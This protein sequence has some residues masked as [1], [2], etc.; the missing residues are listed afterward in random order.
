MD[1]SRGYVHGS[2]AVIIPLE[3]GLNM[4]YFTDPFT[5]TVWILL[6]ISL[7]LYIIA[8]GLAHYSYSGSADWDTLSG[9]VLRNALSEQTG[10]IPDQ[11]KTYHKILIITWVGFTLILVYAYAGS[12]T[13]MLSKPIL[14]NPIKTLEELARQNKIPWVIEKGS[15]AEFHMRTALPGSTMSLLHQK[16]GLVP[17]LTPREI[18]KYGCPT[19]KLKQKGRIATFCEIHVIWLMMAKDFSATGK[20]N[21]YLIEERLISSMRG[22]AFQVN[23]S[24]FY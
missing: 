6:V 24:I 3:T 12:L 20:C 4:W 10:T 22:A 16:A 1:L 23:T 11:S 14:Q 18:S 21:Y 15:M 9:F 13:A 7:P 19:A 8:M 5:N 17:H 2:N